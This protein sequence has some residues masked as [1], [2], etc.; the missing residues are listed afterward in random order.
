VAIGKAMHISAELMP[1]I[2][3]DRL[4]Q[5]LPANFSK[6]TSKKS[7]L[8]IS[9]QEDCISVI[10]PAHNGGNYLE[11]CLQSIFKQ[12]W[13]HLEIIVVDD[14]STDHTLSILQQHQQ[15]DARLHVIRH[16]QPQGASAARNAGIEKASGKFIL[17]I[18]ADDWLE[19]SAV[20]KMMQEMIARQ[21]DFVIA[22]HYRCKE[23]RQTAHLD[24]SVTKH[25]TH[26]TLY[27][28]I[29]QYL[30]KPYAK[31]MLVHCWG[32]LYKRSI[33]EKHHIRF[34][35]GLSQFEDVHFNFQY[36]EK[37]QALTYVPES[38]YFHRIHQQQSLSQKMGM[39]NQF[40]EKTRTAFSQVSLYLQSR[41]AITQADADTMLDA[42][43]VNMWLVSILRLCR[44]FKQMPSKHIY[45]QI[46]QIVRAS[47]FQKYLTQI[48]PQKGEST[49]LYWASRSQS[50]PLVLLAGICRISFLQLK[51]YWGAYEKHH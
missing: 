7:T 18:D 29:Q 49:I 14:G 48:K 28:Y 30:A 34:S 32:R 39:E 33:I 45:Q 44:R 9:Q 23:N 20:E 37:V 19:T 17:F 41:H 40:L 13:R 5:V 27:E 26:A 46:A 22:G 31:V 38:L 3:E 25:F 35:E 42:T 4:A 11:D 24:F 8:G 6:S 36:L 51:F 12:S 16:A 47:A 1:I 15:Q 43:V 21:T 50:V 2:K 10:I